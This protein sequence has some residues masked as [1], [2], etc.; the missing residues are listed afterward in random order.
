M[1]AIC[2]Q[3]IDR[4]HVRV[5]FIHIAKCA[6][7]RARTMGHVGSEYVFCLECCVY[8]SVLE[9]LQPVTPGNPLSR[10]HWPASGP[11]GLL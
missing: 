7:R 5:V 11:I 8:F 9:L 10:P 1:D 2:L 6:D 3:G 4:S